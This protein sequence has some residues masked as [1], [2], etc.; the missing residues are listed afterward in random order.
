MTWDHPRSFAMQSDQLLAILPIVDDTRFVDQIYP[1]FFLFLFSFFFEYH[2]V[3]HSAPGVMLRIV[4]TRMRYFGLHVAFH[5]EVPRRFSLARG[6]R[7]T[8]VRSLI[9]HTPGK[10][11]LQAAYR[12]SLIESSVT[13]TIGLSGN[14]KSHST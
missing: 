4:I 9:V 8:A 1:F 5:R 3:E 13:V 10:W 2:I 6:L 11:P 14:L 7:K 12:F